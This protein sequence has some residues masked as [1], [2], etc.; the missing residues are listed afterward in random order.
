ME[1][2]VGCVFE[3]GE[4]AL[5]ASEPVRLGVLERV[6]A[7]LDDAGDVVAEALPDL[8]ERGVSAGVFG[9]V[10]EERGDRLVLTAAVFEHER[11]HRKQMRDVGDRCCL[12]HLACVELGTVGE[13]LC[14]SRRQGG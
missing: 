12:A 9:A 6:G 3:V 8:L 1:R 2:F 4:V 11:A 10:V 5:L 14:E 13:R 7:F